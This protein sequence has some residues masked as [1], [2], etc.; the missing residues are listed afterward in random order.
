MKPARDILHKASKR[1]ASKYGHPRNG[2]VPFGFPYQPASKLFSVFLLGGSLRYLQSQINGSGSKTPTQWIPATHIVCNLPLSFWLF[3]WAVLLDT[4]KTRS[5]DPGQRSRRSL[6]Q[7]EVMTK[8]GMN[9]VRWELGH[10]VFFRTP[11]KNATDT[12]A[13]VLLVSFNSLSSS[14]TPWA[15]LLYGYEVWGHSLCP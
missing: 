9:P 7:A 4:Y 15:V 3:Y 1:D 11:P 2:C 10:S 12:C 6:C 14:M 5:M 13:C 8:R